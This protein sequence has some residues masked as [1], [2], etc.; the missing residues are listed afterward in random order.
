MF[1]RLNTYTTRHQHLAICPTVTLRVVQRL[2]GQFTEFFSGDRGIMSMYLSETKYETICQKQVL[3][4]Y[5]PYVVEKDHKH[6][7]N[8]ISWMLYNAWVHTWSIRY[9]SDISYS[10]YHPD[11]LNDTSTCHSYLL[12]NC[13][14]YGSVTSSWVLLQCT[15]QI[16]LFYICVHPSWIVILLFYSWLPCGPQ[17]TQSCL[18]TL[19][20]LVVL[21]LLKAILSLIVLQNSPVIEVW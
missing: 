2:D 11:V 21:K 1:I 18:C 20:Y 9:I 8:K 7:T 13:H 4:L 10:H 3:F 6:K 12:D 14:E 16:R 5:W 17:T 19:D 15:W